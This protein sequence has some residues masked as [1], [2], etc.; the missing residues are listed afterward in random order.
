VPT[1]LHF[2][3]RTGKKLLEVIGFGGEEGKMR[4]HA[5]NWLE[6]A[7]KVWAFRR[8]L[9][10]ERDRA[11]LRSRTEELR[12]RY[13]DRASVAQLRQSMEALDPVVKRTGGAIYPKSVLADYVDFLL[14]AAIVIIGVRTYFVQPFKIPTNSMWPSYYGMTPDV[15][16]RPED[17]PGVLTRAARFV[18]FGAR[19]N[20]LIAPESGSI[21]IPVG[22]ARVTDGGGKL[23]YETVPAKSWFVFPTTN[24]RYKIYVN[25]TELTIQVPQDFDFDWAFQAAFG[26]TAAQLEEAASKSAERRGNFAWVT[27]DRRAEAGKALLSFDVVTGDQLF[28][29]RFSYHFMRPKVGQGFVFFTGNIPGIASVMGE[30]YYIKR[31]VGTPGDVLQIKPPI[32]W[33][34]GQPI[35]G[36]PSFAKN[37]QRTDGYQGYVHIDASRAQYLLTDDDTLTVPKDSFFAMGDNSNN[38]FDGRYWGFVPAKEVVGRPLFIYFPFSKRWGPSR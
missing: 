36:A 33:R 2:L 32:L 5:E 3:H 4:V 18:F 7:D 6:Q 20:E 38:S 15:Y 35:T 16:H 14:V 34:N 17:V 25:R 23:L 8:D 30:Q 12:Q 31:L 10:S 37:A 22:I 11:E 1:E 19:H 29:D 21:T 27:L 9:L 13:R 28:V 24:R 26:L